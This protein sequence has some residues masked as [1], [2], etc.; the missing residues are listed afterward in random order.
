MIA[1]KVWFATWRYNAAVARDD[2][3]A[4]RAWQR[5]LQEWAWE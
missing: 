3:E 5:R 4:A 2:R 1:L